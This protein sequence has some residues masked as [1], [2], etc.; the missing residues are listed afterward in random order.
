MSNLNKICSYCKKE[1]SRSDSCVRH[2]K[3]CKLRI[4][5]QE[6]K[7]I[8]TLEETIAQKNKELEEILAQ[9]DEEIFFLKDI[10]EHL[11]KT[12]TNTTNN[13]KN[14]NIIQVISKLDPIDF[15]DVSN[16]IH[17]LNDKY[18]DQGIEGFAE[19]LCQHPYKE[20]FITSDHSRN[21]FCFRTSNNILIK[22]PEATLLINKS[23]KNNADIILEKASVRKKYW[24]N[25]IDDEIDDDF[26]EKEIKNNKNLK[27]LLEITQKAKDDITIKTKEIKDAVNILK[28]Y[29]IETIQ[30]VLE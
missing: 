11:K 24:K 28:K 3:T 7:N 6:E 1:F 12:N 14:L 23:L 4:K 2:I 18:I 16:N 8:E 20:K 13:I 22:D 30:K 25:Q 21:T 9:K 5:K 29:G 17:F 15:E 26:Q 27:D 10:I 19:F